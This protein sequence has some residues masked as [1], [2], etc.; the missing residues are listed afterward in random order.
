MMKKLLTVIGLLVYFYGYDFAQT[1]A[2]PGGSPMDDVEYEVLAAVL[3]QE[4][5]SPSPGWIMLAPLTATFECNPPAHNGLSFGPCGGMRTQDQTPEEVLHRVQAAIP[6]VSADLTGDLLRKS[7]QSA[8]I[9]RTL[10]VPAKQFLVDLSGHTKPPY[11]GSPA[12]AFYPS[13]VGLNS[14]RNRALVYVGVISWADAARSLGKFIYLEKTDD[15]WKTK[16]EL[17][18]WSLAP[19]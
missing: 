1:H 18:V 19:K 14:E 13:R 2:T 17:K 11:Q 10:P 9:T 7:Q 12:L 3:A 5:K 15:Q 4:L 8:P 6:L 16:G